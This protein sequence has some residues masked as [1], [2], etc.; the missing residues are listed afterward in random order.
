MKRNEQIEMNKI[1]IAAYKKAMKEYN[2][3]SY[4]NIGRERLRTCQAVVLE[5][6]NYYFLKSYATFVAVI[7]KKTGVCYD[8]LRNVFGYTSTSS[9][10]ITKFKHDYDAT[11]TYT[12][13][14]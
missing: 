1:A 3:T 7:D 12:F 2:K 14:D 13:R 4:D 11:E 9:Q 6:E 5:T 8:V 10:H